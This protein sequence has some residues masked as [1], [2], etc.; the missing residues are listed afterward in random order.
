MKARFRRFQPYNDTPRVGHFLARI[1]PETDKHPN[2]LRA[3]WEY[4]VS[5]VQ[6][7]LHEHL[8]PFGLWEVEDQIVALVHFE[9]GPGEVFFQVAPG[10]AVLK[11]PMV[12]YAES[13]LCSVGDGQRRLTLV[14]SEFDAEVL[15]SRIDSSSWPPG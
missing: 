14:V 6:E 7:R 15:S 9:S 8:A 2:W 13:A 3:R 1:Y 4:M 10:H 11:G 5:S 12:D